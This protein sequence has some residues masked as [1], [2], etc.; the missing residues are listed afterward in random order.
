[1]HSQEQ[2]IV[3]SIAGFDPTGGAGVLADIQ[4]WHQCRVQGM[5]VVTALTS[6]D[7]DQVFGTDWNSFDSV[8]NQLDPLIN[9]YDVRVIKIG[10]VESLDFLNRLIDDLK[11]RKPDVKIIW[12]PII[13]SS[14]GFNFLA[15]EDKSMLES[16]LRKVDLV[17]PNQPEYEQMV[18]VLD[19]IIPTNVLLKGGHSE[20]SD[21][22]DRLV[23]ND[24][25]LHIIEGEKIDGQ[26]KHGTGCVLSAAIAAGLSEGKTLL[27]SCKF[28]KSYIEKYLLSGSGKLGRH[29]EI[30]I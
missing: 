27:D 25:Q 8:M 22:S 4:T 23:T 20:D 12:D 21:T 6:Q 14:S 5:A 19:A 26:G 24:G 30:S 10:I 3:L 7:E 17:T 11:S 13:S 28:A 9:R 15:M 18:A 29:F 16:V 2:H 1:M